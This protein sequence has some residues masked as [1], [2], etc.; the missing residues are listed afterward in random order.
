MQRAALKGFQLS[1]QQGHLWS[2]QPAA[3]VYRVLCA[4]RLEGKLDRDILQR[5]LQHLVDRHAILRT[6]YYRL[7]GMDVPMQVVRDQQELL[8]PDIDLRGL[9]AQEQ[10]VALQKCIAQA[11]QEDFDLAQGP[12]LR[13]A[14]VCC[15]ARHH[16]L[17]ISLPAFS[18]D[19]ATLRLCVLHLSQIY[20]ACIRHEEMEEEP[21]QY[22]DVSAWQ[23]DLLVS[24]DAEGP[25]AYWKTYD[26]S[27][28]HTQRLPFEQHR[29][30]QQEYAP[31][32]STFLLSP[33]LSAEIARQAESHAVDLTSYLLSC[34]QSLLWR[35]T[36]NDHLLSGVACDGRHYEELRDALGLYTRTLPFP[37]AVRAGQTFTQVVQRVALFLNDVTRWQEYFT[38]NRDA[39]SFPE[40]EQPGYF[41]LS[42]EY[43]DWSA[44][45][46]SVQ[47]DLS[48]SLQ[49]HY[50][51][52][53]PGTLKLV[54]VNLGTQLR[55][56]LYYDAGRI[57]DEHLP[58][59]ADALLSILEDSVQHPT[60]LVEDLTLLSSDERHWLLDAL[61]GP[62]Q[63]LSRSLLLHQLFEQQVAQFP[64]QQAVTDGHTYLTY[65]HLNTQA[66]RL[67]RWLRHQGIGANTCVGLC[68]ERSVLM[69]VGMLGILK[70][71]GSYVPLDPEHPHSRLQ[72]QLQEVQ[73]SIVLTQRALRSQLPQGT[74]DVVCLDE[75]ETL[76]ASE[77]T[78]NIP[79][80]NQ[81]DDIAYVIY[82]S[83]ST[84]HPKGVAIRHTSVV[85]YTSYMQQLI[86]PQP[87]LHFATVS[88]LAAD[89]GNTVIFC[90]LVSGGCLHIFPY[91]TVTDG[92]TFAHT[93][94]LQPIDVLKI[95]PSH[96]SALLTS[97]GGKD[98]LPRQSL[99]L[100]GEVLSP[101]L[102]KELRERA[103]SCAIFNHYGP[104]ETT[105]GALVYPIPSLSSPMLSGSTIPIGAP[106]ANTQV[107][108]LDE[109]RQ[110]VPVGMIGELY[111][112][113]TGVASGYLH[114]PQLTAEHF[115]TL[116]L[117]EQPAGN[118]FYKTGD[119]VRVR[120]DGLVEF[121]GRADT[122]I[123]LRGYRI[124]LGEIETAIRRHEGVSDC[125]VVLR[126]DGDS[127]LRLVAYLVPHQHS[128]LTS[129]ELRRFIAP[130]LPE[131][132]RPSA[133]VILR[134]FPFTANGK[135]DR[136]LL[137]TPEWDMSDPSAQ[138]ETPR[139]PIEEMLLEIWKEVL[140]VEHLGIRE[141]F[142]ERGGHS[143]LATQV[144]ARV[145]QTMNVDVAIPLLFE[146]PTIAG[147]ATRIEETMRQEDRPS[148]PPLVPVARETALPLS[149]AQQRLWFLTQLDP[150]SAFY[151]KP[152]ALHL[153]GS[154]NVAALRQSLLAIIRRHDIL[155]TTFHLQHEQ[156]VQVIDPF[157]TNDLVTID[158]RLLA[159]EQRTQRQ[160]QIIHE[161]ATRPL[162]LH[163]GPLLR[164]T[165]LRLDEQEHILLLTMHHSI[166][167][168]W[169]N[170]IFLRELSAFY[171][172]ALEHTTITLPNLAIQYADFACWQR[173]WLQGDVLDTQVHYWRQ[174]LQGL[175]PLELP[176]DRPRP[177]I[178][179]YRGA[180][181]PVELSY[182]ETEHL[183]RL[184]QQQGVTLFMTL[185][186]AFQVLLAYYSGQ[187][188]IAVGTPVANRMQE[189]IE[190]LIGFFV[191]TLVLRTDI[192][193]NPT[194]LHML[195]RVRQ[196]AL[197]AYAHQDIPFEKVVDAL[198]P[199]RD[200]SRSPLFQ[201]MFSLNTTPREPGE[202]PGLHWQTLMV[203]SN[204]TKFDL[205]LTM[206][207]GPRGL[208]GMF[209]Y[210]TD[211][212]ND[213]TILRMA[214]HWQ[215]LLHGLVTKPEQPV[216]YIHMLTT[217]E[218]D[219][220]LHH[221]HSTQQAYSL[222]TPVY[223]FF[224]EQVERTPEAIAIATEHVALT[225]AELNRRAN[226][227]A[228]HLLQLQVQSGDLVGICLE[229]SPLLV[230][231]ILATLKAGAA[232]VPLDPDYPSERLHFMLQDAHVQVVLSQQEIALPD[233]SAITVLNLDTDWSAI[234][235][236]SDTNLPIGV[237]AEDL[238]YVIYTSG[239]TGRPKGAMIPHQALSNHM[240]W[241]QETY[242][243]GS[244]ER[245][246]QRTPYS[247]DASIWEFYL[248]LLT[249]STLVLAR[250]GGQADSAYLVHLLAEQHITIAQFVPTLLRLLLAEPALEETC[251]L[252]LLFSGGEALSGELQQ[253]V[254]ARLHAS[255][256]NL[257][258]PTEAT[259]DSTSFQCRPQAVQAV[260]PL[261][262]PITN[263]QAYILN[264]YQVPVP[265]GAVG[266]LYIGGAGL[267]RGYL[268]R[269]DVTA[270]R[271][272]PDPFAVQPGARL[273]RTG[274]RARLQPDGTIEFLGRIDQQVK[275]RGYRIELEEIEAVIRQHP[276]VMDAAVLVKVQ[277]GTS[278]TTLVAYLVL[279][280]DTTLPISDIT[281]FLQL[282]LPHYMLPSQYH[283][284]AD[285]P[286][287]PNGK[288]DR[289]ALPAI[290]QDT[291]ARADTCV[292]PRTEREA[293]LAR[294]WAQVL[295]RETP[296]IH[297][298]FFAL[299]GD[300]ILG[301]RVIARAAQEGLRL[302]ARHLFQYQ[303]IAQLASV[304]ETLAPATH[305][306]ITYEP[307]PLTPVQRWF[308][309]QNIP[310]CHHFNQ[311]MLLQSRQPLQMTLV[312]QALTHV[313]RQHAA[314]RLRFK[315]SNT[316]S[317]RQH[318]TAEVQPLPLLQVDLAALP[319]EAQAETIQALLAQAHASVH[320]EE[321]PVFRCLLLERG[322]N[323]TSYLFLVCHHLVIDAVSWGIL[324]SDFAHAYFQVQ[325]DNIAETGVPALSFQEWVLNLERYAS[326][327]QLQQELPYWLSL[328]Q[329]TIASLPVDMPEGTNLVQDQEAVT[330]VLSQAE[331]QSLLH[332][333][334][335]AYHTHIQDVLLT[336]LALAVASWSG[337][338]KILV[339]IEGHGREEIFPHIDLSHTVGWFTTIYPLVLDLS[340]NVT[341]VAALKAIKEQLR[342]IPMHGIGYGILRYLHPDQ[343]V[344]NA[345]AAL[346]H[347]QLS[348]NYLGQWDSLWSHTPL[349]QPV[350]DIRSGRAA[351][352]TGTRPHLLAINCSVVDGQLRLVWQYSAQKHRREQIYTLTE[353]Y[354]LALRTVIAHC[355]SAEA[356]GFTP[357]DFPLAHLTQ[358][359][360][361]QLLQ[362]PLKGATIEALY[363][364]SPMQE[365]L[366][367]HSLYQ[368]EAQ[369]YF[370]QLAWTIKGPLQVEHWQQAWHLVT[371]RHTS[372][373][374]RIVWEGLPAPLQ[375]VYRS[376]KLPWT[377]AD[378][379][380]YPAEEQQA[381]IA[382]YALR[383]REQGFRFDG[384]PLL[385]LAL[386]QLQ[387]E[388]WYFLQSHH[389]LILD[390]WSQQLLLQEVVHTYRQLC[391][392]E[393][394]AITPAPAYQEYIAW[395]QRQ[396]HGTAE[397]FWRQ[398]LHGFTETTRLPYDQH[399]YTREP[400]TPAFELQEMELAPEVSRALR[401]LVQ[402]EQCTLNALFQGV[403]ALL[404]SR[405][406]GRT[407]VVF[408]ATVTG[409]PA[410]L[411]QVERMVGL[412]IN[413][414]PVR[415][416]VD[417]HQ[418]LLS[419]LKQIQEQQSIAQQYAYTPLVNIQ[420]WSELPGGQA[421][422]ESL[423]AFQNVPVEVRSDLP[424]GAHGQ[425][426][427]H[428]ELQGLRNVERT[429]YPLNIKI[430]VR[431]TVYIQVLYKQHSFT[432]STITRMLN[433][434]RTVLTTL[435]QQPH[436]PVGRLSLLSPQEERQLLVE[437]NETRRPYPATSTIQQRFA[438]QVRNAP[439]AIAMLFKEHMVTYAELDRRANQL[440]HYAQQHGVGPETV[441]GI[442]LER[443]LDLVVSVLG[444]L[445]A[446]GAYL[447]LDPTH[448]QERLAFM[449][450][451]AHARFLIT[452]H[453][454]RERFTHLSIDMCM[455]DTEQAQLEHSSDAPCH[456]TAQ[457]DA[458]A[459]IIYTS[460][461]TGRPKGI[462]ISHAA[463][464]RLI[465]NT[466]YMQFTSADRVA[467]ISNVS[468][469][470][471]TF[472]LWGALLN[473]SCL[474][475]I[476]KE[477]VLS[478][479][480]FKQQLRE[481]QISV[482]LV[483][484]ALLHQLGREEPS[485]F[486]GIQTVLFGG[487]AVDPQWVRQI[488][489]HGAPGRL[490]HAYGPAENTTL[491]TWHL[492]QQVAEGSTTVPIGR[493]VANTQV[494]VLDTHLHPVPVGVA[495]ELY[496]GGDGLARGYLSRPELT[497]ERFLPNPFATTPGSRLYRTGDIVRYRSD[498]ALEF[499]GR[500]DQ[501]VKIRGHRIEPGE[502]EAVLHQHPAVQAG[503]VLVSTDAT[504]EKRL[505]AYVVLDQAGHDL[506]GIR[507]YLQRRLP[508]YMVPTSIIQLDTLPLTPNGKIDEQ[509][510]PAPVAVQVERMEEA[511]L[512][513]DA[514]EE[515]LAGIWNELLGV[516]RVALD[517]NFFT[518]GGHSL[519]AT[520]LIS[521]VRQV[522]QVE[523]P[524][525]TLFAAPT[526]IDFARQV[527]QI[528]NG[529]TE[530]GVPALLPVSRTAA[531]PLSFA[532]QRLWFL[533]QMEPASPHYHISLALRL[534]GALHMSVLERSIQE[535]ITRHESL[536]TRFTTLDALPVQIIDPNPSFT[537]E[538]QD[539]SGYAASH[540]EAMARDVLKQEAEQPFHLEQGPLL[541]VKLLRQSEQTHIFSLV[542]HHCIADGWSLSIFLQE[543][544]IL[545][546]AFLQDLPSP[547]PALPLQYAD[548]AHWQRQ[549]LQGDLLHTQLDYWK[550]QLTGCAPL[551][552]PSDYQRPP[553]QHY[554][555]ASQVLWLPQ[556]L[557]A[558]L[559]QLSQR[560]GVT[561]FMTL[562]AAFQVLLTRYSG[563]HDI[564]VG[565]PIANRMYAETE[566]LIGFFVNTLVLR[567][568]LSGSPRFVDVVRR[569]KAVALD[570]YAHQ[571][572]PFEQVVEALHPER[573]LSRSPLFQVMFLLQNTP[574]I[575][576]TL[577]GITVESIATEDQTAKFDLTFSLSKT[578]SGLRC[579]VNYA[580][581]LFTPE[582]ITGM[583][584]HWHILLQ[585][586][587]EQPEQQIAALPLLS[588][589]E[590]W[591][592][593]HA[594]NSARRAV[595]HQSLCQR[596]ELQVLLSPDTIALAFEDAL[597]TYAELN[598]LSNR[599]AHYLRALGIGPE[600]VVGIGMER[601]LEFVISILAI[602]KAGG[603]YLPL[604]PTYPAERLTFMCQDSALQVVLTRQHTTV[605]AISIPGV[606]LIALDELWPHLA[607]Q[608]G[609]D[610]DSCLSPEQLAYIIYTSGST[611]HPKGVQV[612]QRGI[613][614]LAHAQ[615][616]AF[617]V[618]QHSRVLQFASW[619]FDASVSELWLTLL[620]GATL[621][622]TPAENLL[623]GHA[624]L[625]LLRAQAITTLTLP[626]STLAAL[627]HEA[628]P[629]LHTLVVAGE[630]SSGALLAPW[631][632]ERRCVNAYGPTE[633]T[634][635]ATIGDVLVGQTHIG[636]GNAIENTQ[637]YVLNE[638]LQPLPAGTIG[639]IYL[640]GIG[641]A[642]GYLKQPDQ[643]AERFVPHPYSD[644]AG[645]RLYRTGDLGRTH[646][647]GSIEY[648]GRVDQQVKVRGYRIELGE[649]EVVLRQ[650]QRVQDAV[651]LV[652]GE[653]SAERALV[654]YLVARPD[655]EL[656]LAELRTFLQ[657]RLPAYMH[658]S[659][660]VPLEAL[661]LLPN[662]KVNRRALVEHALPSHNQ[663]ITLQRHLTWLEALLLEIWQQVL[664]RDAIDVQESF[665]HLGGHSLLAT[666]VI[667]RIRTMLHIDLPLR[668]LFEHPTLVDLARQIEQVLHTEGQGKQLPTIFRRNTG[669][670]VPLSFAQ[671]R[672]WFLHQ[673]DPQSSAYA[674]PLSRRLHGTIDRQALLQSLHEVIRRHEILRTVFHLQGDQPV[675]V[676][677][678]ELAFPFGCIDV[679]AL[680]H[681]EREHCI[682]GLI[683]Q[684]IAQPFDLQRGPLLRI[685]LV[686]IAQN[687]HILHITMH[688]IVSDGWSNEILMSEL[689]TL[690]TAFV[691]GRPAFLPELPIQYADFALWQRQWLQGSVLDEQ[692]RYWEQQLRAARPLLLP[693]DEHA[694]TSA[695]TRGAIHAFSLSIELSQ[696]LRS[697]AVHEQGGTL[698]MLLLTAFQVFLYRWT[699]QEDIVV[700]T[701]IANRR[702]GETEGLIGFFVN[703]LVLRGLLR[704]D[705]SFNQ[706]FERARETV[707][708]AYAHQDT[709]FE[710][711]IERIF[712][713]Y[714]LHTTPLVR[715]LFV[716]Q[717]IPGQREQW[718]GLQI[719]RSTVEVETAK[720]DL[721]LFLQDGTDG[722]KGLVN[723]TT[724]LFRAETIETL[725]QSF[726]ILLE[727]ILA[728]PQAAIRQLEMRTS[729]QQQQQAI[730][731]AEQE[732]AYRQ[733]LRNANKRRGIRINEQIST[734]NNDSGAVNADARS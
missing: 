135:V 707:L 401:E 363:P 181:V 511:L 62:Q 706:C 92:A 22:T 534:Q 40:N 683:H 547:L 554:I 118:I 183:K 192:S 301:I 372:L 335:A 65:T 143:L 581:N 412:F 680:P 126:E 429:N 355:L 361:D 244:T 720:F 104:T 733:R 411:P 83:G 610:L 448:P 421:L 374:S 129:L 97:C 501:Q 359:A 246:L 260:A 543:V 604:D 241:M 193:D 474:V 116:S 530:S 602:V 671:Q 657:D 423:F 498:G 300:S 31:R 165:L 182:E 440:A 725:M 146:H 21:L 103:A 626:P 1:S 427:A 352:A 202:L 512:P 296:G 597:L 11:R 113:G 528:L 64:Q 383:D 209:E 614:N 453:T 486:Q 700:G 156:V 665:F 235:E 198:Q 271:F 386:F 73:A 224:E 567:T 261:G 5:A 89:L 517:D 424:A 308:F 465:C 234:T 487:E 450:E 378:W 643:T 549:W 9:T 237:N 190:H 694:S 266:E 332:D 215:T 650:H 472:E 649:V 710:L 696:R 416:Q 415:I 669:T 50:Q 105:I 137:P 117:P 629:D 169:S 269:P 140:K 315:Q 162:L 276:S 368:P 381:R 653:T 701:D 166:S 632:S 170:G 66:N 479:G 302:K 240:Q 124:E 59:L 323:Q 492:V 402:R 159:T 622:M 351:S 573:D 385:R 56:E 589:T 490:L 220:L 226:Q 382:A 74:W 514:V 298:N 32:C 201:V 229:R 408:G 360:L 313:V 419:W 692:L 659:A 26:L 213:T 339:D 451:D 326:S 418:T 545:Y 400:E 102:L 718:P 188:D 90:S 364:L 100:G 473:G 571:D 667:A 310:H 293:I 2:L 461:S 287:L 373:R 709:P 110:M 585:G 142:F 180:H 578:P 447:P 227:L 641:M 702:Q 370:E 312:E 504:G 606:H 470:A 463:I 295:N 505:A 242:T 299:G 593:L 524:L 722:I 78:T 205:T 485:I 624:F 734:D 634:V 426:A 520:R 732:Q 681:E 10:H 482:I 245:I 591:Q 249:G 354:L 33:A 552:L 3:Q 628:V 405:Y 35:F 184:S 210:N 538:L 151:T 30:Q 338:H 283:I 161:E 507:Q 705:L 277:D 174:Q 565:T 91:E 358:Q 717:N 407:D 284:L 679:S 254:F 500:V 122:Q 658:P 379:R 38:W 687:E 280:Q 8:C 724:S 36:H 559:E 682:R 715:V 467:Q 145:R 637:I 356:G 256:H 506:A 223:R 265:V 322:Q 290:D 82:T 317:W 630:A 457:A 108:V 607:R 533:E 132:M 645:A 52:I 120:A 69:I 727:S 236:Y 456:T 443:S 686:C 399:L 211:L 44:F 219:F 595:A 268:H 544:R 348:F 577:P 365:G 76:L 321:G 523:V 668:T 425:P 697:F 121:V 468:F 435:Q 437:W 458:L 503:V 478:A 275:V 305:A 441:T 366:F 476:E 228:R 93:L 422:F 603:A 434:I 481:Q 555:G 620:S 387:D 216:L 452:Q 439:D 553:V 272:V 730:A 550:R 455:I 20:S 449:L 46:L 98:I 13:T 218:R 340:S 445:K 674:M 377:L 558:Q 592:A 672:L 18:A 499:L 410:E 88:T 420:K 319:E 101:S 475:G 600:V 172:A 670:D 525:R 153:Q 551:E 53:T 541:R 57:A 677:Q 107:V 186:A 15:S 704:G 325:E 346:P 660:Y 139:G 23:D 513:R 54:V 572:V 47:Q 191:N 238:A 719:S 337:Q 344:R 662:G 723:Y 179:S 644:E 647:D 394:P 639:E 391:L 253:R 148:F 309:E 469:D 535:I 14:L 564:A 570:A 114:Q 178:Q 712:P 48:I 483:T 371:G 703:V 34:W 270:E 568:D 627:P 596:F 119:L 16:L 611:G 42:F 590:R 521:R 304:V 341:P 158:L 41:P 79:P 68:L 414:L 609:E 279:Q 331:T 157:S 61:T 729:A 510:L 43:E 404:L 231:G 17:L 95:V 542:M 537:L 432:E 526:L 123:K 200:V 177:L 548:Y 579:W 207:D 459:L 642:R 495:G 384:V 375:V 656:V 409:R 185:C 574:T 25:V 258:G 616:R 29:E 155:R 569:V 664:K 144:I 731:K 698:F 147:M 233:L 580:V 636:L 654:A 389:H 111:I 466:N 127:A 509:A 560:E 464:N 413:T 460:G 27:S 666:Q 477:I 311:A 575:Q 163:Q 708:G 605:P 613:E 195:Q 138:I 189:E 546:E 12:L 617:A 39:T 369:P 131:A 623:P 4:V 115:L 230:I 333:V 58:H 444:I 128:T 516:A 289:A 406:S 278:T 599:L 85:N 625:A 288:I 87:G 651:V 442:C 661:P 37:M 433:H 297:D 109:Q 334:P 380:T 318:Y 19:A 557:C 673:L 522:L 72:Y 70:A 217:Q 648:I 678:T 594:R 695:P 248:P 263:V 480:D 489:T 247:F 281:Q 699:G 214:Q 187:T 484:T 303:T 693:V 395:L 324:L 7:P 316:G 471:A 51:C 175:Q 307:F 508:D 167:D 621:V 690:Y 527:R 403:W 221:I 601:S 488:L 417:E 430:A 652:Q 676:I 99:I 362:G 267:A 684:E 259:V 588:D 336:A 164:M 491:T 691:Q 726:T 257:Y 502:I 438:E 576:M 398:Y 343:H 320:I 446:G 206:A 222:A 84:G 60:A 49:E 252:R 454:L 106:I 282:R 67:A 291:P 587:V 24:E 6:V 154:L 529:S 688:H 539:I 663:H 212:F 55:L 619:N 563:Q 96:L 286:V 274:D 314:L 28:L 556:S 711:L 329:H 250:P 81:P 71:G 328:S 392:G 497:A 367:F 640:G 655:T 635:C 633:L 431:D 273:Y 133:F 396:D 428:V 75:C 631:A 255:L 689:I 112:G 171:Q 347:A 716:L 264:A 598:T 149:F 618:S 86:A 353:S 584:E 196:V 243:V 608:S 397:H 285:L 436:V 136:R 306:A 330:V 349:L 199:E 612:T 130:L 194:F 197:A 531:L 685:L 519:L 376:I 496:T 646:A 586:I 638:A 675:Q 462:C 239:T 294:I 134:A 251:R 721:A 493:P 208:Q 94:S 357:S 536:R 728:Q 342:A 583:L 173:A 160:W 152:L 204:T 225:Y 562:L 150:E 518:L 714:A 390:G 63:D 494:Y 388:E 232:Y 292:A 45:P 345:L 141:N 80:V 203:E 566:G 561:L 713:D 168:A 77:A 515:L 125:V 350:P 582:R 262:T 393:V 176:T 532:Q 327:E 615:A 540:Q